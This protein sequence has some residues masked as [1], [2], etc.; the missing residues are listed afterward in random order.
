M[1]DDRDFSAR[2]EYWLVEQAGVI[3]QMMSDI[4]RLGDGL[5]PVELNRRLDVLERRI[6][7][8]RQVSEDI[9]VRLA[10]GA[11]R[12]L[13]L[14]AQEYA[15]CRGMNPIP[16][17]WPLGK[18]IREAR[19]RVVTVR[20]AAFLGRAGSW[21]WQQARLSHPDAELV[22]TESFE[23]AADLVRDGVVDAAVLPIDNSTAGS[24]NEVHDI[25]AERELFISASSVLEINNHLLGI[26]GAEVDRI[27]AVRSHPQPLRQCA[28]II[29][30]NGWQT[31][32]M[33]ST[34][35]AAASVRADND[36]TVAAIGSREAAECCG[37]S[38]LLENVND[39][40]G[41]Q[42]RFVV[43]QRVWSIP[44]D[45]S[46]VSLTFVLP[47]E[48]GSLARVLSRLAEMGLN[49]AK[50]QSRPIPGKPW[51]YQFHLDFMG[52]PETGSVMRAL[53]LLERDV[54][55]LKVLGWYRD[56]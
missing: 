19:Q 42:T 2:M 38:V 35:E 6:A 1:T 3:G 29:R 11:S 16:A 17:Q 33:G 12:H 24:I 47:H 53:Y 10:D 37:L 48:C 51:E 45:A 41:N 28:G 27:R 52:A 15:A 4:D 34:T 14:Q 5:P 49:V 43:V 26:E 22:G 54:A 50:I 55:E 18:A 21:S 23:A 30:L 7:E 32:A 25:L 31:M 39:V 20:R 46:R 56:C 44:E 40:Q 13:L 9:G 36:P 8:L